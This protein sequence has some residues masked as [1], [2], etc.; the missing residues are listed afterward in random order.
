MERV[1]LVLGDMSLD[2]FEADWEKQWLVERGVEK[3]LAI[4]PPGN[5][6]P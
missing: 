4:E 3:T 6:E 2:A 1:Q 5:N